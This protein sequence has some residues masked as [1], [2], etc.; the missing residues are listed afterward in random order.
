MIKVAPSLLAA[1]F[2]VLGAEVA[3]AEAAGA[4][5]L[6]LDVMDGHFVP[7]ITFGP[8]VVRTVRKLTNLPLD[9]H[10]M[11]SNPDCFVEEFADAGADIIS[12]HVEAC[13]HVHRIVNRIRDL[14][15][16]P[17]VVLNPAT[18]PETVFYVLNLVGM[19]T[20]MTVNPGFGGQSFIPEVL[21]KIELVAQ[22]IRRRQLDVA[23]EVDGGIGP[24]T[25]K[26]VTAAGANVL[27][28]GSAVFGSP[29]IT[30]AINAIRESG[31]RGRV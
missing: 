8:Q 24:K 17:A 4:D 29:D 26:L 2:S 30:A 31:E 27:V 21:P 10:L 5:L 19:V 13:H 23:L 14:G 12:F 11:V 22:K 7:N 18:P 25:A 9:V 16:I 28:A 20:L 15:K 6:H 1:D 3:R